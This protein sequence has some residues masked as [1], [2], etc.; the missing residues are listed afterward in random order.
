MKSF[1]VTPKTQA[2]MDRAFMVHPLSPD[3]QQRS[4]T[5]HSKFESMARSMTV[6]IPE[7]DELH[8]GI[9]ALHRAKLIFQDAIAKSKE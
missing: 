2:I 6:L 3:Q 1:Q 9:K 5:V 7:C 4:E 8:E